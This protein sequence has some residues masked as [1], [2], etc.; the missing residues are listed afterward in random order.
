MLLR[1]PSPDRRAWARLG[2]T[3]LNGGIALAALI[4]LLDR[5]APPQHVPWTPF[6]LDQRI[7]LFTG[8]KLELAKRDPARCR[9]ALASG[10]VR[11]RESEARIS[12]FCSTADSLR[13]ASGATP[14]APAGPVMAC[15]LALEYA[16]WDR[17]VVRPAARELLDAEVA[18][19]E[20]F[21]TYA[22]RR[23]YG[24]TE[25]APSAHARA[26]APVVPSGAS[27]EAP[28]SR[29][30]SAARTAGLRGG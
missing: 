25:G 30:G 12:G 13:L 10:A 7:G 3:L 2:A 21:G 4:F 17:Q 24:R 19:V 29:W 28:R 16:L 20:H 1:E 9:R 11:F 8:A 14:L 26:A 18:Q 27:A 5:F 23:V 6:T 22:C 15:P